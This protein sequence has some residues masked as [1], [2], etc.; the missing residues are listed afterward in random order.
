MASDTTFGRFLLNETLPDE[1][2]VDGPM[3]KKDLQQRMQRFAQKDPKRYVQTVS[4]LKKIGDEVATWEGLSVGLDDIQPDYTNRDPIIKDA[5]SRIKRAKT[6]AERRKILNETEQKIVKLTERHPSDMTLMAKSGGRGSI[7]QLMKTVSSPIAATDEKGDIAPWLI[8]KSYAEGLNPADAWVAGAEARRGV[9]ASTGSVVE[10]GAVAKVVTT[11]MQNLVV[12]KVDCGTTEGVTL[13]VTDQVEDR[14]LARGVAGFSANTLITPEVANELRKKKVNRVQ[15]RSAMTCDVDDGVCQKCMGLNEWG[16][17]YPVGTNVGMRSAQALTEPLTQFVLNAKHGVRLAGGDSDKKSLVGLEGFRV[18]TEVPQSFTD[19]AAVATKPGKVESVKKAPQGG[20]H[21][22][23]AGKQYYTPPKLQPTVKVGDFVEAGD[24]LTAGVAMPDEVVYHKGIGEGRR[25]LSDQLTDLYRR[26]G[27]DIDRRHTELL[28]RNAV[29][30]VRIAKDPTDTF[31]PGDVVKFNHVKKA[32]AKKGEAVPLEKAKGRALAKQ[33]L[34]YSAGTHV[35]QSVIDRLKR[36]GIDRVEVAKGGPAFEP[37]MKS[38]IRTPLLDDDWMSRLSHRY[39]KKTL[40]EGAGFGMT[41]DTRSTNPVPAYVSGPHFGMGPEGKYAAEGPAPSKYEFTVFEDH[42]SDGD[43]DLMLRYDVH[44]DGKNVAYSSLRPES[45][46]GD[47]PWIS[48]LYVNPDFRGQGL[49][50]ALME[51][52]EKDHEGQMLRMRARP[53]KDKSVDTETLMKIYKGMG[54][55]SY[56]PEEPTRMAKQAEEKTAAPGFLRRALLGGGE[57]AFDAI[58]GTKLIGR[59]GGMDPEAFEAEKVWNWLPESTQRRLTRAGA[60]FFDDGKFTREGARRF[61]AVESTLPM[62]KR[63]TEGL[64][65]DEIKRLREAGVSLTDQDLFEIEK[66]RGGALRRVGRGVREGLFG[67]APLRM[68]KQRYRTGGLVG[69]GGILTGE[70]GLSPAVKRSWRD[71]MDPETRDAGA[72][73]RLAMYGGMDV[74]D[75][76]LSYGLPAYSAYELATDEELDPTKSRGEALGQL[77][78]DVLGWGIGSP[79]GMIGGGAI[80]AGTTE[81]ARQLGRKIDPPEKTPEQARQ[82]AAWHQRAKQRY[83]DSLRSHKYWQAAQSARDVGTQAYD[84][85][86]HAYQELQPVLQR[87][88]QQQQAASPGRRTTATHGPLPQ[89]GNRL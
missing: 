78:G 21:I 22:V 11:N 36:E 8:T 35:T 1:I 69:P 12:T 40:V 48:G 52:I 45:T 76:L 10:P 62:L 49:A 29:N 85:G 55:E 31:I 46:E 57:E 72:F 84:L 28:A 83:L 33:T 6:D 5:L 66:A 18:L 43:E 68:L 81:A 30:Y 50:K 7:P 41:S 4:K 3:T 61:R 89:I 17:D 25:Y 24:A 38:I 23:V 32:L 60:G 37:I 47:G 88:Q 27:V 75:K 14:Y 19:R 51:K 58:K 67:E 26:Q 39:L 63:R 77:G 20:W 16:R 56:D 80:A 9:I 44:K 42:G 59:F 74:G 73:G 79:F 86:Q 53:Y 13:P 2:Q 34:H 82:E 70:M 64:T 54:F 71:V 87:G 65:P 15:V